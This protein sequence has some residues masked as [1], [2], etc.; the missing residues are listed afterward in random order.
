MTAWSR[1]AL[2]TS[3]SLPSAFFF[4]SLKNWD[5]RKS[6]QEQIEAEKLLVAVG[7]RPNTDHIGLEG[8]RVETDRGFIKVNANQQTGE[9]GVYAIG[10]IVAGTPQL[11][12]VATMEAD[13]GAYN[14]GD[15]TGFIRLNAL[16]LRTRS[17]VLA[18]AAK[19]AAA[20]KA[21][22]K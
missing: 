12:H 7:R 3:S 13:Q 16:R 22:K 9:P 11:A 1:R 10:D 17:A 15:A 4:V 20:A 18:E 5:V 8:T 19:P 21:K 14:Q 2:P 6:K